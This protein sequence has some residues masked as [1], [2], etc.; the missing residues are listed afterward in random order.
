[1]KSR[2]WMWMNVA[3]LFAALAMPVGMTAQENLLQ[4]HKSKHHQYKLIDVGTFGGPT[5]YFNFTGAPNNLLSSKGLVTA[6][7]DTTTI[8]PYCFD[9]PDCFVEHAFRWQQGTLTDLGALPGGNDSE[10][11]SINKSGEIAGIAQNGLIDPLLGGP[12]LRAVLWNTNGTIRDLGNFGGYEGISQQINDKG[13]VVGIA[14]NAIPDPV[15][16]FGFYFGTQMRAFLWQDGA[17]Q[18]LGTLGGPDA[19]AAF[20]NE[21]GQVAGV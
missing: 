16:L 21:S 18:D 5:V 11:F 14:T 4:D 20:V 9:Y 15:S 1:M 8:D 19:W 12:E 13:Q 6:G 3:Y 7:A 2:T 10:G 17:M